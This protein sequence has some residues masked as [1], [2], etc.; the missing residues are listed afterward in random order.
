LEIPKNAL[1]LTFEKDAAFMIKL[2]YLGAVV[3]FSSI[4]LFFSK[5]EKAYTCNN[6][7][8]GVVKELNDGKETYLA[9]VTPD[10]KVLL[11]IEFNKDVVLAAGTK[12]KVCYEVVSASTSKA[13]TLVRLNGVTYLP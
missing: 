1:D 12:V 11:P 4:L 2:L 6:G 8:E 13:A 9:I 3:L 5:G 10:N 7:I